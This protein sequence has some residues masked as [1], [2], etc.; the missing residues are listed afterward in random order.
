[1][2][3]LVDQRY[4]FESAL[5]TLLAEYESG[6]SGTILATR[7]TIINM[8]KVKLDEL[9]PEGEGVQFSLETTPNISNPL[10]LFINSLLDECT[11][12]T[13]MLAP[14]HVLSGTPETVTPTAYSSVTT[15]NDYGTGW[16]PLPTGYL[17]LVSFKMTDWERPVIIPISTA[18]KLYLKQKNKY[19]RGGLSKPVAAITWRNNSGAGQKIMEYFSSYVHTVD[20]FIC[21][22]DTLAENLQS[23]LTDALTWITAAK[24]LQITERPD[25]AAKA[26]EQ[27]ALCFKNM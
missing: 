11:K 14:I 20:H 5:A 3:T 7:L 21:V 16:F 10:D 23:D 18:S 9:I 25:L 22:S 26:M 15:H 8:V 19:L 24:I 12:N 27:V 1:M 13:L 6:T 17:R 2:G 4:D